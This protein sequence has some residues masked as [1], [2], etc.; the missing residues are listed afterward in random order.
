MLEKELSNSI[1]SFE[2]CFLTDK[3][4]FLLDSCSII[5]YSDINRISISTSFKI[6]PNSN[7]LSL[8]CF[9]IRMYSV[10]STYLC[11]KTNSILVKNNFISLLIK[12]SPNISVQ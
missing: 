10:D 5:N 6:R 8:I 4:V 3:Y 11:F 1:F 7:I 9:K 12:R 2:N